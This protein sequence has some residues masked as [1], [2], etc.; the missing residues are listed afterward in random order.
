[1]NPVDS[2]AE[3]FSF[4]LLPIDELPLGL[5]ALPFDGVH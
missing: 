1:M 5:E 4:Y 2:G 3:N